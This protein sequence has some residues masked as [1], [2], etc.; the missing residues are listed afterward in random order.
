MEKDTQSL[1]APILLFALSLALWLIYRQR[2]SSHYTDHSLGRPL[3]PGPR[4]LPFIGNLL[5]LPSGKPWMGYRDL[6]RKYGEDLS[7]NEIPGQVTE[8][9]TL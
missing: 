9:F 1:I 7:E 2:P 3:P 8:C 5:D 4:P 6:S